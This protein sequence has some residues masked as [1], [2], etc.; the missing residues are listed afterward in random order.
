MRMGRQRRGREPA[1]WKWFGSDLPL[2]LAVRAEPLALHGAASKGGV[3]QKVWYALL[4]AS[5]SHSSI[6][7]APSRRPHFL[8]AASSSSLLASGPSSAAAAA[9]T[10]CCGGSGFR[11]GA[12][13]EAAAAGC[14]AGAVAFARGSL[15]LAVDLGG[16]AFVDFFS[17]L[18]TD[19][20]RPPAAAAPAPPPPRA[21]ARAGRR[22]EDARAQVP[23]RQYT[24]VDT[25]HV[26]ADS[27][28]LLPHRQ[29][30]VR[31]WSLESIVHEEEGA[32]PSVWKGVGRGLN[33]VGLRVWGGSR[34]APGEQK[35][36]RAGG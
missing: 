3:R 15:G 35:G 8:H 34:L 33:G 7:I 6:R 24:A 31:E 18:R 1:C 25:T 13:A 36:G 16:D 14:A 23:V 4:H 5:L 11:A 9:A 32:L 17:S 20:P 19:P 2:Q 22:G 30:G 10:C 26:V 28:C 21:A 29:G 12:G 27:L